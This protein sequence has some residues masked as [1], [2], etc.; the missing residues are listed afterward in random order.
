MYLVNKA[1]FYSGSNFIICY[2]SISNTKDFVLHKDPT[3][4]SSQ[5]HQ[6]DNRIS[7]NHVFSKNYHENLVWFGLVVRALD[8]EI[9][10]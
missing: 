10:S 1:V 5:K 2:Q 8:S 6:N 7:L 9:Q 3:I 4:M